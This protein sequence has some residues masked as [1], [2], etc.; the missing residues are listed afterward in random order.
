MKDNNTSFYVGR[1]NVSNARDLITNRLR[2][3]REKL[4]MSS[5]SAPHENLGDTAA[6]KVADAPEPLATS[7]TRSGEISPSD[8]GCGGQKKAAQYVYAV[9]QLAVDFLNESRKLSLYE[10]DD[11]NQILQQTAGL[12]FGR[13]TETIGGLFRYL[14]GIDIDALATELGCNGAA[15]SQKKRDDLG[16]E[17]DCDLL[18]CLTAEQIGRLCDAVKAKVFNG[19]LYDAESIQW[20]L[21]QDDCPLY[22][23]RPS[24]A[25]AREAYQQLLIFFIEQVFTNLMQF[26]CEFIRPDCVQSFYPCNGGT[27][28][29][30]QDCLAS[31]ELD[32][33]QPEE[34]S[35]Q[36]KAEEATKDQSNPKKQNA[37]QKSGGAAQTQDNGSEFPVSS[38]GIELLGEETS[39]ASRIAI[40]GEIVG[41][42]RLYT[43]ETVPV[44]APVLRGCANWKS[45]ALLD[46]LGGSP[47]LVLAGTLRILA[48]L[49]EHVRNP[50]ITDCERAKNYWVT[51]VFQGMRNILDNE[52]FLSLF[53]IDPKPGP[54]R[55]LEALKITPGDL[56]CQ[57]GTC[58]PI[59]A[60]VMDVEL[61][62]YKFD[63]V[64]GGDVV[65]SQPIDVADVVPVVRGKQRLFQRRRR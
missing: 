16:R 38:A 37:K 19:H 30:F 43:G 22:V 48:A 27:Q 10:H 5:V 58:N 3:N 62:F 4:S 14:L 54:D 21:R 63:N 24:G 47:D 1:L 25:F 42:T 18:T 52:Y 45:S 31:I 9:G 64:F 55:I 33:E 56:V 61:S 13:V 29:D 39:C 35:H 60:R 53:G 7:I 32:A 57:P 49:Y 11:T 51:Q 44:V 26:R 23:L 6:V 40:A 46:F 50:G 2:N 34:A 36:Q 65:L 41:Q 20:V 28:T 12:R 15:S 8:C 59:G 17:E